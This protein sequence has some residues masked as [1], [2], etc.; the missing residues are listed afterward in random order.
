MYWATGFANEL[1]LQ[2][3]NSYKDA[4]DDL[5]DTKTPADPTIFPRPFDIV[6][7]QPTSQAAFFVTCTQSSIQL[8]SVKVD[9]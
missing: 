9:R 1:S 7:V 5:V 3:C 4:N 6:A 2:N 8:W